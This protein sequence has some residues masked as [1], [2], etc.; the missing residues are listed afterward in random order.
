[1]F[2]AAAIAALALLAQ[3]S[4]SPDAHTIAFV[5]GGNVWTV[6][7]NGG[8]AH[9]LVADGA[10]NERPIFSP[11]GTKLAYI[12]SK[13]GNGDIYVLRLSD[14]VVSRLTY[15]DAYDQLDGWSA[16]G[17]YVYFDNSARNIY[18]AHDIY[19]VPVSGGTPMRVV[20]QPYMNVYFAAPSPHD[21]TL[22][23]DARGLAGSQW[24]RVG[25]SHIDESEI[26]LRT[27]D[28]R[29]QR[30]TPGRAKDAWPMW[31]RDGGM[32]YF[33]SD[34]S[35]AQNLWE[36]R[37]GGTPHQLTHFGSGRVNWPSTAR[38]GSAIVFERNFGIWRYDVSSGHVAQLPVKL[39][40]AVE[41]PATTHVTA[42]DNFTAYALSPDGKKVAFITQGRLFAADAQDGGSAQEVPLH[43][44]YAT[45][46][47][48]WSPDSDTIAFAA[49]HGHDGIIETYDFVNDRSEELTSTA[50]D[51]RYLQYR[52]HEGDADDQIAYET[53][54]D[55]H[56]LSVKDKRV[57]TLAHQTLP[58]EPFDPDRPL[59]WSPD[60]RWLAFFA[61]EP[62]GFTNVHV[63]DPDHPEQHAIS[64]L[65]NVFDNTISWDPSGKFILFDTAQRT[66][67]GQVARVDLTPR[68][69][70]FEETKFKEL[71]TPTGPSVHQTNAAEK[72][73][74]K[75]SEP[76]SIV[77]AN[78][79]QRLQLLPVGVDVNSESI[80]PDGKSLLLS[81][82][83]AGQTNLYVFPLTQGETQTGVAHQLTHSPGQKNV[84]AWSPDGKRVYYLDGDGALHSVDAGNGKDSTLHVSAE[85][86]ADWNADKVEA[87]RQA[88]SAIRDFY[89]DPH[90]N[91]VDW[92]AVREDYLP[93]M[94]AAQTP[95]EFR[96][97]LAMMVGELNSSHSGVYPPSGAKRTTGRLGVDFDRETYERTGTL[98]IT[99]VIPQ[100]PAAVSG[101]IHAGDDLLAVNGTRIT[102]RTNLDELLDNT[103]GKRVVLTIRA[104]GATHDVAV[105]PVNYAT[106][107]E[108]RY[109]AWVQDNRQYV[110]RASGG[111]LGYVHMPDMSAD[112]LANLYKDLNVTDFDKD[113]V[114]VDIRSNE[115]G[116][117]NAYA[118]DVFARRPYLRM[119]PRNMPSVS[120]RTELGQRS[121]EKPTVLMVNEETL[122]DG[123]DFTQGYRALHLGKVV[124]VPTAG[125]II[126]TSGINLVDGS[127]FRLPFERVTTLEGENMER[128][129]RPVDVYVTRPVGSSTDPQLD[130]A[131][132]TLMRQLHL[133]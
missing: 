99:K 50:Q 21:E 80:S 72:S 97:L 43:G 127:F 3:P 84:P 93:R 64:F 29:Y 86:D 60:G 47:L 100:S 105:Q 88:W 113:G 5:S 79:G 120:A 123:E 92:N 62:M 20:T 7:A 34:R 17:R 51:V 71:F 82:S 103:I 85:F 126:Y 69:P 76:I 75:K 4:L 25:H 130:A 132:R 18:G 90:T 128:N 58:W 73:A 87:F 8:T 48:T 38:N 129:P 12:S 133:R 111:R 101:D 110:L 122:S 57:R 40:G 52:P 31:S 44:R 67:P 1:M 74:P 117:V 106:A 55:V 36:L 124:G 116:F 95:D 45:G 65:A 81:A 19:R 16:D 125:W 107:M 108:L 49:G 32:L 33:M 83:A 22:A 46:A 77:F 54:G 121:L 11:D 59:Q 98:R 28:G 9:L 24:W 102:H 91:G 14:G 114:V 119:Y 61:Q 68:T 15:D 41:S 53:P 13:S 27:P 104:N 78:I 131:V 94:E 109:R 70:V 37:P 39:Q 35:G 118:I 10:T 56:L 63:I 115:G 66:E 96:R 42:H 30:V 89:A 26:W 23:F 112:S 6:P 2:A